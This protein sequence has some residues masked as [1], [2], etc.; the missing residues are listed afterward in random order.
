MLSLASRAELR[1]YFSVDG[2]IDVFE[3]TIK[4]KPLNRTNKCADAWRT[5]KQS[6][7]NFWSA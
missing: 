5:L 7:V 4:N 3:I 6:K 2:G 1:A